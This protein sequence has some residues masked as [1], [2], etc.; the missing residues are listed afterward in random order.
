[1]N[2]LALTLLAVLFLAA[3]PALAQ[4]NWDAGNS[5]NNWNDPGN[6]DSGV[7]NA[8][9]DAVI[10]SSASIFPGFYSGAP[11][12]KSLTIQSTASLT[13]G[14]GFDLQVNG[15]FTNNGTFTHG[16]R[17]VE[18]VGTG[19]LGGTGAITFDDLVVSGAGTRTVSAGFTVD[20]DFSLAAGTTLALGTN[21]AAVAGSWISSGASAVVTGAGTVDFTG[22]GTTNTGSNSASAR[23]IC[24]LGIRSKWMFSFRRFG[25]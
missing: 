13:L 6:W 14:S 3:T 10:L 1:M 20:G 15:D 18:L 9:T 7:P 25:N 11:V 21:T 4:T 2:R 19:T 22:A 24:C 16:S 17:E 5:N 12:T 8:S 23:L